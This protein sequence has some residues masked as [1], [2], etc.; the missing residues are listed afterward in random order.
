MLPGRETG[1]YPSILVG[2]GDCTGLGEGLPV[3]LELPPEEEALTEVARGVN[4]MKLSIPMALGEELFLLAALMMFLA[5]STCICLL[6]LGSS[7]CRNGDRDL[8]LQDG[9]LGGGGVVMLAARKASRS[10]SSGSEIGAGL[11]QPSKLLVCLRSRGVH[12]GE[13]GRET[14][15]SCKRNRGEVSAWS[16]FQAAFANE[17]LTL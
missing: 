17:Y 3:L 9:D 6:D 14:R 16:I 12:V 11:I 10:P 8:S 2:L 15:L 5:S 1:L 4:G 13:A 7:S